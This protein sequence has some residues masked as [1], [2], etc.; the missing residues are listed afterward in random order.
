MDFV[1]LKESLCNKCWVRL[2]F[3]SGLQEGQGLFTHC[4]LVLRIHFVIPN[5][6]LLLRDTIGY[7]QNLHYIDKF[8][9]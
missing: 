6:K 7:V 8:H 4:Y 2:S 9:K 3:I 1:S 5:T